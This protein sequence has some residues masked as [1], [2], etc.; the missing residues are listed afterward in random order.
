[1]TE[2]GDTNEDYD[3]AR[4]GRSTGNTDGL[5]QETRPDKE[6]T[7]PADPVGMVRRNKE[8][9]VMNQERSSDAYGWKKDHTRTGKGLQE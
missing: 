8:K 6:C 5:R 1:M 2:K 7:C 9:R 4:T 3:I